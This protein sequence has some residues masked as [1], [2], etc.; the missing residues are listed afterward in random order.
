[1]ASGADDKRCTQPQHRSVHTDAGVT[2]D[3]ADQDRPE[4]F[5]LGTALGACAQTLDTFLAQ[6]YTAVL[7]AQV[8]TERF[9]SSLQ[10]GVIVRQPHNS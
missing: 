9:R 1:M 3:F 7:R 8:N 10:T 2:L 4:L 5:L 6:M